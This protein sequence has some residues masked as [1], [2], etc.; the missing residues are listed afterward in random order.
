M[1]NILR[2]FIFIQSAVFLSQAT[3]KCD[4]LTESNC[5]VT[6]LAFSD[7]PIEVDFSNDDNVNKYFELYAESGSLDYSDSGLNF[8][9]DKRF[10]NPSLQSKFYLFFGKIEVICIPAVGKGIVSTVYLQSDDLDEIDLE[11]IGTEETQVQTNW[12]SKGETSTYD[13]GAYNSLS[14]SDDLFSTS[15]NYTIDWT[16]E[17]IKWYIDD[18]LVRTVG[19]SS[20]E[21]FPQSPMAVF[22][23]VWAGGDPSNSEGTIEWAGGETD[24]SDAPFSMLIKSMKI[25]NYSDGEAYTYKGTSGDWEDISTEQSVS[26]STSQVSVVS[27]SSS[28][29]K[30]SAVSSSSSISKTSAMSSSTIQSLATTTLS[31]DSMSTSFVDRSSSHSSSSVTNSETETIS[32]TETQSSSKTNTSKGQAFALHLTGEKILMSLIFWCISMLI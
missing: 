4:P 21:G 24:Y 29:S 26:S 12:F 9:L 31:S 20:S 28:I 3:N 17:S 27:S 32:S 1:F 19:N 22:I 25:E 23:G 10:D 14:D 7:T 5:T 30:T 15:H 6:D 18:E 16:K 13:R 2:T 8:T 11:W